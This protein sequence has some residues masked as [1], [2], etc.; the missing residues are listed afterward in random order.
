MGAKVKRCVHYTYWVLGKHCHIQGKTS[1]RMKGQFYFRSGPPTCKQA[2]VQMKFLDDQ[3]PTQSVSDKLALGIACI[4]SFV[5]LLCMAGR[6]YHR[7]C[8]QPL[9]CA[10]PNQVIFIP[11]HNVI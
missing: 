10:T 2:T 9:G 7:M 4:F 6:M 8:R 5:G 3:M 1:Y 11:L